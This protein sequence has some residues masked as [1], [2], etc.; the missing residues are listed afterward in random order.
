MSPSFPSE[1]WPGNIWIEILQRW[2][3][4]PSCLTLFS[5]K[6]GGSQAQFSPLSRVTETWSQE[7]VQRSPWNGHPLSTNPSEAFPPHFPGEKGSIPE[8]ERSS[9]RTSP[10]FYLKFSRVHLPWGFCSETATYTV[11]DAQLVHGKTGS[12]PNRF[13]VS[14]VFFLSHP[15]I[16]IL[17]MNH[18]QYSFLCCPSVFLN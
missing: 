11:L 5:L 12:I 7:H 18:D 1:N 8:Q 10:L 3:N 4:L 13:S 14:F 15:S 6:T 9:P 17:H 16:H 2:K